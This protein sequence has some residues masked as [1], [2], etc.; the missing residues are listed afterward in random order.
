MIPITDEN[1]G[2][3]DTGGTT[4]NIDTGAVSTI[5]VDPDD[6]D[7]TVDL[8]HED[9]ATRATPEDGTTEGLGDAE[10]DRMITPPAAPVDVTAEAA[11][12]TNALGDGDRGVFL[13]WNQVEDPDT[14]TA[15]YRINR[16]RMNTGV[17]ALN[18][19][20]DAPQFL[21]RVSDV[22]SWTDPTPLRQD[23]ETRMYQV[24]SEASGVTDPECVEMAVDYALHLEMHEPESNDLMPAT[25]LSATAGST[26]DTAEVTWTPGSNATMH[27]IYAIRADEMEGGY[28]FE[29]TSSNNSHTLTGLDSGV[30]YIV[31]V[32]A[33]RGQLP[34][35]EW[36]AWM[37]TRVTPD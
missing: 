20:A 4:V 11:S 28:T 2:S 9:D 37:F 34:G 10:A 8:P 15:S 25:G 16:I 23:E 13:T 22:T 14:E 26:A 35:G 18:D 3:K 36:S 5:D 19:E 27:W 32:S 17:D 29:Q 33:G 6:L 12:D 7:G 24:C 30:E 31:G 21:E 1:D